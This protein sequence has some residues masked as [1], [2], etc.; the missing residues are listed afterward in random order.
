MLIH[1]R[2]SLRCRA[3]PCSSP[4]S[5]CR[6]SFHS[7][8]SACFCLWGCFFPSMKLALPSSLLLLPQGRGHQSHP[9]GK[10]SV[11]A[12]KVQRCGRCIYLHLCGI[13]LIFLVCEWPHVY[14]TTPCFCSTSLF[15]HTHT[16]TRCFLDCTGDGAVQGFTQSFINNP[17]VLMRTKHTLTINT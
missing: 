3:Q 2:A 14:M 1:C 8:S 5:Q 11:L 15:H 12:Q 16:H 13:L 10:T 9:T 7:F 4:A 6:F 17:S